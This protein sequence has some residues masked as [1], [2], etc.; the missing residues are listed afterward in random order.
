MNLTMLIRSRMCTLLLKLSLRNI[1]KFI[2]KKSPDT[3]EI[4]EI[5]QETHCR[6]NW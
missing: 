1:F 3:M 6:L 5:Q 4:L 2:H